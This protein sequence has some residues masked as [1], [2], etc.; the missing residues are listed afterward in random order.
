M[1]STK[2]L[3]GRSRKVLYLA[4]FV[5][6]TGTMLVA[7]SGCSYTAPSL[8]AVWEKYVEA[9]K[10]YHRQLYNFAR[11]RWPSWKDAF[12]DQKK[13]QFARIKLKTMKFEYLLNND[14]DRL[15]TEHGIHDFINLVWTEEDTRKLRREVEGAAALIERVQQAKEAFQD[16]D[17]KTIREEVRSLPEG[18]NRYHEIQTAFQERLNS[19]DP[20]LD[21]YNQSKADR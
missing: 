7:V 16:H 11:D 17:W 19:L 2:G 20:W 14:P 18:D 8:K 5:L 12:Q 15:V 9:F 1:L 3:S 13:Y 21:R 10:T 4:G 6:L